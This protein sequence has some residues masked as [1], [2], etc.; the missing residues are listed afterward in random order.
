MP[1]KTTHDG[2]DCVPQLKEAVEV[3][4]SIDSVVYE[5]KKC[6]RQTP[7]DCLVIDMISAMEE[8][9]EVLQ[10]IENVNQEF[11]TMDEDEEIATIIWELPD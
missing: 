7:L 2:W 6:V 5:I 10:T 1:I 4:E 9:I 3:L 11:V 8:A